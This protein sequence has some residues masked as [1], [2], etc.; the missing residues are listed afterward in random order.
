M[1]RS[2]TESGGLRE[3]LMEVRKGEGRGEWMD[4]LLIWADFALRFFYSL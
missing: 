2:E 1:N 4:S 3:V